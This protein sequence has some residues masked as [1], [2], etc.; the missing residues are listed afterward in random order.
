M[1][2][3]LLI[4]VAALIVASPTFAQSVGHNS[5]IIIAAWQYNQ[6]PDRD[7]RQT[8]LSPDDQRKF[9]DY[10][11]KWLNAR[12]SNDRDDIVE[13]ERHMQDIMARYN[14]PADVPFDRIASNG[15]SGYGDYRGNDRDWDRDRGY[16]EAR[17]SPDDQAK[18]D[19]AYSKWLEARRRN[20]CDDVEES[21]RDMRNIMARNNIPPN[22]PYDAVASPGRR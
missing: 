19:K 1:H 20:D 22:V 11:R 9:D 10:Y 6:Y 17:L 13:N 7:Y 8:R 18:F 21:E 5:T 2:K 12:R 4:A 14:I 3:F 15:Y 16:G